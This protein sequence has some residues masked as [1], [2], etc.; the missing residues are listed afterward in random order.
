MRCIICTNVETFSES[1]T[2]TPKSAI[3]STLMYS[4]LILLRMKRKLWY[5]LACPNH[6][7][8]RKLA[9][10]VYENSFLREC[11]YKSNFSTID[12]CWSMEFRNSREQNLSVLQQNSLICSAKIFL[13]LLGMILLQSECF[14]ETKSNLTDGEFVIISGFSKNYSFILQDE[15]KGYHWRN[16]P[17]TVH[18]F[19]IY[20]KSEGEMEPVLPINR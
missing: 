9:Q 1:E 2:E 19:V 8:Y 13:F 6:G 10:F 14:N 15:A 20:Y 11:D 12:L 4:F 3:Y 7:M 17:A 16:V 5:W 18:P